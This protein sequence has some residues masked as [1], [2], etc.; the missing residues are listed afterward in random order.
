MNYDELISKWLKGNITSEEREHLNLWV[1]A[2]DAN[3]ALLKK[4]IKESQ[5]T[6]KLSFDSKTALVKFNAKISTQRRRRK[7]LVLAL[8]YTAVIVILVFLG[9]EMKGSLFS[10]NPKEPISKTVAAPNLQENITIILADGSTRTLSSD[11]NE[12][13][14]DAQGNIIADKNT[15]ALN[16]SDQHN[17]GSQQV[18]Y[19]E[20]YIPHGQTFKIR[21][22]DGT[23]VWLNAGSKLKFPTSFKNDSLH[24]RT[25]FLEGEGFFDVTQNKKKPFLVVTQG[26]EVKV[27]GT[28]FNL[29]SYETDENIATTLIEGK[30]TLSE[31][32][33]PD[34]EIELSPTFQA[35][36][37][38]SENNFSKTKVDTSI[39]T[40]WM[41]NKLIIDNLKFSDILIKLERVHQ[42]KF[43]NNA[44]HLNNEVFKGEFENETIEAVLNT[45]SLSTPFEYTIDQNTITIESKS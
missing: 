38:K 43:L 45:I 34:N 32:N 4:R 6:G 36:Y 35:N 41:E 16:F 13:L 15:N 42:V 3:M 39:Y 10:S 23:S 1:S 28:Q 7:H 5:P 14:T 9:L 11:G 19:N 25:V 29:S 33:K 21:L 30:V 8:P 2:S 17:S 40:A 18:V 37:K 27:L 31:S 20:I 12:I 44:K 24:T 22:S 26:V